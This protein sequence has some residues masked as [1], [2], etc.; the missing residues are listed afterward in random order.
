VSKLMECD[1]FPFS[2]L[3]WRHEWHPT[4]KK[5]RVGLLMV[6]IWQELGMSYNSSLLHDLHREKLQ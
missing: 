4:C 2:A 1:T 5:L 6:T 3:T